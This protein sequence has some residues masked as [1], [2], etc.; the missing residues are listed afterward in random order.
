MF[1]TNCLKQHNIHIKSTSL[2]KPTSLKFKV[3]YSLL[4]D[5]L[6]SLSFYFGLTFKAI[7]HY[8]ISM[9]S[10]PE[11]WATGKLYRG[12]CVSGGGLEGPRELWG[13]GDGQGVG[14]CRDAVCCLRCFCNDPFN[15]REKGSSGGRHRTNSMQEWLLKVWGKKQVRH[16][17]MT[18]NIS[19]ARG[20]RVTLFKVLSCLWLAA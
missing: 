1:C 16:T 20:T 15:F 8:Y 11:L 17:R 2:N 3:L 14:G 4:C 19:G 13:E 6:S 10:S 9:S 5:Y 18:P 12:E 7:K